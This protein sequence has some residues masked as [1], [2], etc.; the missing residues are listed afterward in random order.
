MQ[1]VVYKLNEKTCFPWRWSLIKLLNVFKLTWKFG[2]NCSW[3]ARRKFGEIVEIGENR[4][5]RGKNEKW[6]ERDRN[7]A[8][9]VAGGET[10]SYRGC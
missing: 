2:V 4:V 9:A 10:L 8:E 6:D 1:G 5:K 3:Q 7:H